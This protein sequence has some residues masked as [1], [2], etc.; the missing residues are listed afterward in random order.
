[1]YVEDAIHGFSCVFQYSGMTALHF[2]SKEGQ[3]EICQHL[4]DVGAQEEI[5]D[6]VSAHQCMLWW[7]FGAKDHYYGHV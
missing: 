7:R 6:V 2:A 5:T 3:A 1:M 4:L